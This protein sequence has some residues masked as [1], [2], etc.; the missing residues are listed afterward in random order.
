[1]K[2]AVAGGR[3]KRL[4]AIHSGHHPSGFHTGALAHFATYVEWMLPVSV[5]LHRLPHPIFSLVD[6][7]WADIG[8]NHFCC[9]VPSKLRTASAWKP[10]A[11]RKSWFTRDLH[12]EKTIC[13]SLCPVFISSTTGL[14]YFIRGL[15]WHFLPWTLS[16]CHA[17]NFSQILSIADIATLQNHVSLNSA[18]SNSDFCSKTL[19]MGATWELAPALP[20]QGA[21]AVS[22]SALAVW[23]ISSHWFDFRSPISLYYPSKAHVLQQLQQTHMKSVVLQGC[24]VIWTEMQFWLLILPCLAAVF[25]GLAGLNWICCYEDRNLMHEPMSL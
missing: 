8:R 18:N 25:E 21:A 2:T 14:L 10:A 4:Q 24:K 20:A 23:S 15:H 3:K 11:P 17:A 13:L 1:M 19:D 12:C 16:Q 6:W 7:C 22:T 5:Q 9:R